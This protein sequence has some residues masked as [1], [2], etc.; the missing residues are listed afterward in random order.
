[1]LCF[2]FGVAPAAAARRRRPCR[3]P[4]APLFPFL[5]AKGPR[6]LKTIN[7]P[8]LPAHQRPLN[9]PKNNYYNVNAATGLCS[10]LG[11][12][13]PPGQRARGFALA[14][15]A[16]NDANLLCTAYAGENFFWRRVKRETDQ[17]S[18]D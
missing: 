11:G 9:W 2:F 12:L 14:A 8:R 18:K 10:A 6:P 5:W 4:A 3:A 1:M 15:D 7:L 13:Q 16:G 17:V